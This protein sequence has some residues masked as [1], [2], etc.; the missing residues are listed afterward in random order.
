MNV[1]CAFLVGPQKNEA[2]GCGRYDK[3]RSNSEK[4]LWNPA[5][6]VGCRRSSLNEMFRQKGDLVLEEHRNSSPMVAQSTCYF[7]PGRTLEC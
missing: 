6:A 4:S 1:E 3:D 5:D 7:V 2:R